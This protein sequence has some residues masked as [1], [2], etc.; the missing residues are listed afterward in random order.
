MAKKNKII[1]Y[2]EQNVAADNL[3]ET[4]AEYLKTKEHYNSR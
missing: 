2:A 1:N 3:H 4:I